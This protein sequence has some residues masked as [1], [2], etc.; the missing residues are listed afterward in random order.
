M[1]HPPQVTVLMPAYNAGSYIK[2]AIDSVLQQTFTDFELLIIN[3]GSEDDSLTIICSYSDSRIRLISRENKG[4]I[5]SLNEGLEA[6][7][8]MYIARMDADDICLS[9]RLE[10]QMYF[11]NNHPDY[12]LVGSE[13]EVIDK[14]GNYLFNLEPIGY[15]HEEIQNRIN[16]KCPFIHPCVTFRKEAVLM[17]GG[18]PANAITFEDHLLWK[19]L[20]SRGKV[21]N[22]KEILLKVR[23][24]PESVTIDEKW[25][26]RR[27][28]ELR[29]RSIENSC[30]SDDDAKELKEIISKQ[31]FSAYK[32]ASYH[33]M[34]GKKYLWNQ[35][36]PQKA[37][38][39]FRKAISIVPTKYE[40]YLLYFL[41][42]FPEK[43]VRAIYN[44]FK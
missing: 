19:E 11:L 35:H 14:D 25:R 36:Q 34:V 42:F 5:K 9:Q 41:S 22:L 28:I 16:E 44:K 26:G 29:R 33:A 15:T 8:G 6:S 43:L 24:N 2:E 13:A 27:F 21:C 1:L 30:V 40:P 4:L 12:V 31:N 18:Y 37:R 20:L 3:D 10:E 17:V 39:H 23:F 32:Q 38:V 7:Q